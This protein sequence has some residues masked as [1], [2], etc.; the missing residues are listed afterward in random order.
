MQAQGLKDHTDRMIIDYEK[1]KSDLTY[2]IQ[3]NDELV[4]EIHSS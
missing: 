2:H 4:R 3:K 1:I